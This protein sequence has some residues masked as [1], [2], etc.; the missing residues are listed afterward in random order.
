MMKN[1]AKSEETSHISGS[2]ALTT[3]NSNTNFCTIKFM[4]YYI[5]ILTTYY[6]VAGI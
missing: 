5:L 3:K 4:F 2:Q 6:K 1:C